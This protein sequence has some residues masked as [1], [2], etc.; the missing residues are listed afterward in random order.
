M[1]DFLLPIRDQIKQHTKNFFRS[2][3]EI[4]PSL[5]IVC[6]ISI[7]T[8]HCEIDYLYYSSIFEKVKINFKKHYEKFKNKNPRLYQSRI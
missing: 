2:S 7:F 3:T 8:V 1:A 6:L 5:E 4:P